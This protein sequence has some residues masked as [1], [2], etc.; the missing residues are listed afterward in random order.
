MSG[1]TPCTARFASARTPR[2]SSRPA[3]T[4][5]AARFCR[6]PATPAHQQYRLLTRKY[7]VLHL[8]HRITSFLEAKAVLSLGK[9]HRMQEFARQGRAGM[10]VEKKRVIGILRKPVDTQNGACILALTHSKFC[11]LHWTRLRTASFWSIPKAP[12]PLLFF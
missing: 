9:T 6:Q 5:A 8:S 4:L 3:E 1:C 7:A 12:I 2:C 11:M 10:N